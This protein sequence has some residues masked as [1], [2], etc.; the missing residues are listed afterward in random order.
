MFVPSVEV[1]TGAAISLNSFGTEDAAVKQLLER[2]TPNHCDE[3]AYPQ[4]LWRLE[5]VELSFGTMVELLLIVNQKVDKGQRHWF[6]YTMAYETRWYSVRG[7]S[8][9]EHGCRNM[10]YITLQSL[11]SLYQQAKALDEGDYAVNWAP[12]AQKIARGGRTVCPHIYARR[13]CV[14]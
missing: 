9:P 7:T 12:V 3:R 4:R 5:A 10:I 11:P 8:K 1:S 13:H 14:E 2:A 6:F